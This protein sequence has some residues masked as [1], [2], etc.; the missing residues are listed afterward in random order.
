[1][2]LL[3]AALGPASACEATFDEVMGLAEA[4]IVAWEQNRSADFMDDFEELDAALPCLT[5]VLETGDIRS[6]YLVDL[7]NHWWRREPY[8]AYQA[9]SS[10][11]GLDPDFDLGVEVALVDPELIAWEDALVEPGGAEAVVPLPVVPWSVWR[12]EGHDGARAV[13]VGRPV[14]VQL[15]DTRDGHLQ[16]WLLPEGGL[17]EGFES[18]DSA[19]TRTWLERAEERVQAARPVPKPRA[20]PADE[21]V[22]ER[23]ITALD[24]AVEVGRAG[25]RELPTGAPLAGVGGAG[26][27]GG[28]ALSFGTLVVA[29]K[30]VEDDSSA[31]WTE[32]QARALRVAYYGGFGVAAAGLLAGGYGV[33]QLLGGQGRVRVALLPQGAVISGA[34]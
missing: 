19:G 16:T 15:M 18:P 32:T 7:L 14:I 22:R 29:T 12:V 1:M 11:Q 10:L 13:P 28:L 9:W 8:G 27:L 3:V 23:E 25:S 2:W 20:T 31:P 21:G 5:G 4:A 30:R 34:W 26:V 24:D 17:P 6:L 33:F